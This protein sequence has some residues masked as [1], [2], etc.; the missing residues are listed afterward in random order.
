MLIN[1][2]R[3]ERL[4]KQWDVSFFNFTIKGNEAYSEVDNLALRSLASVMKAGGF[5][6]MD[7]NVPGLV[8]IVLR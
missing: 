2:D 8:L 5:S 3:T 4:G 7:A 1:E 6:R